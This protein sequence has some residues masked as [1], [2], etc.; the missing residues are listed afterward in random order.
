MGVTDMKK[1]L[2][3]FA[4]IILIGTGV[5]ANSDS[6]D[7]SINKQFQTGLNF[8]KENV[9]LDKIKENMN[10]FVQGIVSTVNEFTGREE[11]NTKFQ[12]V[13]KLQ[14]EKPSSQTFSIANIELGK[15]KQDVENRYGNPQ[16]ISLNEYQT[17]WNTY[18][19][20]YQNFF[21]VAYK[22]DQVVGLFTN[23]DL[24]SSTIGIKMGTSKENVRQLM[25]KPLTSIQKGLVLYKMPE[26]RE[27]DVFHKDGSFIT[28]F[29]DEHEN[30]TVTAIQLISDS[31]ENNKKDIYTEPRKDL[32]DGFE[33]QLFDLTNAERVKHSLSILTWDDHVRIT[34]RDHSLDM[35]KNHYFSHTNLQGEDPFERMKDDQIHFILAGENLAYGQFSSIFAHEGLLNSLGHR[36]NMLKSDFK[37]LGVGVAFN[38][39]SQPFYTE[40]FYAN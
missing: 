20:H 31:L 5:N 22:N 23:Q 11:Q 28:I 4:I 25:G 33:Y 37:Y 12:D 14:L 27:Y 1:L 29:Y 8:V 34:A 36:E 24:I 3:L 32:V 18:H 35:A 2:L 10:N 15:P 30:N 16:R 38:D 9:D 6:K 26:D 19:D 40:N 7:S 21:M 39:E 13:D 17:N